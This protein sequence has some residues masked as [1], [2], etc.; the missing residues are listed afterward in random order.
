MSLRQPAWSE[1]KRQTTAINCG[2]T[3]KHWQPWHPGQSGIISHYFPIATV[4]LPPLPKKGFPWNW[5][6]ALEIKNANDGAI[7]PKRS[8]TITSTYVTDGWTDR[9]TNGHG[10]TAKTAL[11]R[12]VSRLK[13]HQ[14]VL[15]CCCTAQYYTLTYLLQC[16]VDSN[17]KQYIGLSVNL[18]V[19]CCVLCVPGNIRSLERKFKGTNVPRS[20]SS[21]ELSFFGAK[22]PSGYFRSEERK[23]RG[24]KSPWTLYGSHVRAPGL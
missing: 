13:L 2:L 3:A 1:Q 8:L 16:P 14:I 12:S 20:E 4:F 11:T 18:C 15:M 9:Q 10:T 21:R 7:G 19:M 22:V 17:C 6:P 5:V 24:A 23:Y